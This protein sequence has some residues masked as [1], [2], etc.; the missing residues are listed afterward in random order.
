MVRCSFA[1]RLAITGVLRSTVPPAAGTLASIVATATWTSSPR[2]MVSQ[3]AVLETNNSFARK[4]F[5]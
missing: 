1:A 2:P 4:V 5:N 3:S